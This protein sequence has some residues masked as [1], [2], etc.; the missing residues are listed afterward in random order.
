MIRHDIGYNQTIL[1]GDVRECLASL[2]AKSV[3]CVVTSPPYY[4]L[5]TYSTP[6]Q[7]WGGD[8]C[9]HEWGQWTEDRTVRFDAAVTGKTRT[10]DRT[11]GGDPTRR[12]DGNHQK[13]IT[14]QTCAR[15]GAWRGELGSEPTPALFVEHIVEVFRAVRRVLRDDGVAWIN[16]GDCFAADGKFGGET[17]GKQ[18]YLDDV[19]RKKVGREKRFTG[20][21]SG[22]LVGIPWKIA[23]ALRYDGWWLREDWVWAKK[24]SMP[25]SISGVRWARH[26]I[27]VKPQWDAEHPHPTHVNR[28]PHSGNEFKI[29]AEWQDCPGCEACRSHNGYILRRG[30]WRHTRAHEFVFMLAKSESYWSNQEAVRERCV[31]DG[32]SCFGSVDSAEEADEAGAQARDC[33]RSDRER[34]IENGKNP[35]SW[36]AISSEPNSEPHFA[37]FPTQ[38]IAPFIRATCPERCCAICGAGWAPV[39]DSSV[40]FESGSGRSGNNPTGKNDGFAQALS[41]DYDVRMGPV[42]TTAVLDY[43]P[44]CTCENAG[45]PVPGTVID[46]FVGS[47]TTLLVA[48]QLGLTGIGCELSNKYV[49]IAKRRVMGTG[50]QREPDAQGQSRLFDMVAV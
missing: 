43:W 44:T 29:K 14:G 50:A 10:D 34:Y 15:C 12:F 16:V 47:G 20:L 11:W 38:L 36:A 13:H 33:E 49:E 30:R 41:G 2:P 1:E 42:K 32:G 4:G 27:K 26:R 25:E 35:R 22:D 24:N 5:R 3:H 23:F 19:D 37:A 46:I 21:K 39:V 31:S 17:G 48:R 40:R 7:V 18:A 8:S 9:Q 6:P 28:V 45:E